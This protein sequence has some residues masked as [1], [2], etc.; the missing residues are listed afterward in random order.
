MA[1]LV[2]SAGGWN[3]EFLGIR[4]NYDSN[5]FKFLAGFSLK[6][7]IYNILAVIENFQHFLALFFGR[8]GY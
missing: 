1:L 2:Y 8:K 5:A 4:F 7:A 6:T 3:I